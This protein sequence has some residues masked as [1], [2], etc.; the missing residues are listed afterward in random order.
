MSPITSRGAPG[1]GV[2][3]LLRDREQ[4]MDDLGAAVAAVA[5]VG[6]AVER[7]IPGRP[8]RAAGRQ[9]HAVDQASVVGQAE[10][11]GVAPDDLGHDARAAAARGLRG[12]QRREMRKRRR[13][14][15][16]GRQRD[17]RGA[18]ARRA[19]GRSGA[20]ASTSA[21]TAGRKRRW[22]RRLRSSDQGRRAGRTR[23]GRVTMTSTG[24]G[25]GSESHDPRRRDLGSAARGHADALPLDERELLGSMVA[26][27]T[28]LDSGHVSILVL[29][30][31]GDPGPVSRRES[32]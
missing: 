17:D 18:A 25:V 8:V 19:G 9:L 13:A 20:G 12:R 31:E 11:D 3:E 28:C 21:V 27:A 2:V 15:R 29:S 10:R 1:C 5:A 30:P 32:T 7:R 24:C 26:T 22:K 4:E 6:H 23:I 14:E 16:D